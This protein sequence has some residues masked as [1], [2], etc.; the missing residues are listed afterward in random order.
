[1]QRTAEITRETAETQIR[2]KVNLDGT[3]KNQ[4]S[5]GI[6][7]FDHMLNLLSRHALIDIEV[8]AKGDLEVDF[9]HTVEDVGICLGRALR[10]RL[11]REAQDDN[12]QQ[13]DRARPEARPRMLVGHPA[14]RP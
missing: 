5:T 2:L 8:D 6:G 13:S 11:P 1:M 9:H 7:F 10:T 14:P 4:I 12:Q 3:G